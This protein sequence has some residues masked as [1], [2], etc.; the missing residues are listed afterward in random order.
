MI[1]GL[2]LEPPITEFGVWMTDL[3][4]TGF[5]HL[6]YG[7]INPKNLGKVIKNLKNNF[8]PVRKRFFRNFFICPDDLGYDHV[9][10]VAT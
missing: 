6:I 3:L 2:R 9:L 5:F 4:R 1:F 7:K 8:F 10:P